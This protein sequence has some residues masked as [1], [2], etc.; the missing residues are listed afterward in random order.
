M[1]LVAPAICAA[2]ADER[3]DPA[4]EARARRALLGFDEHRPAVSCHPAALRSP[5]G[6]AARSRDVEHEEAARAERA[7]DAAEERKQG[8][9]TPGAAVEEVVEALPER[10]H[11]VARRQL[12]PVQRRDV[13]ARARDAPARS[14][15]HGVREVDPDRL[16]AR[17]AQHARPVPR[18][19]AE[20]DDEPARDPRSPEER[21]ERGRRADREPGEPDLVDVREVG[22]IR[23]R[24]PFRPLSTARRR[25]PSRS[26]APRL[27]HPQGHARQRLHGHR[28][29]AGRRDR[30]DGPIFDRATRA[31][32]LQP[33]A[34]CP[35]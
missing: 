9:R 13:E 12:R 32:P 30:A 5:A 15:H 7:V 11:G 31:W 3:R 20:V 34:A 25:E 18:P 29:A 26:R 19:A 2:G 22:S 27:L 8:R 21:E 4:R 24:H 28:G 23:A 17:V 10:G 16:V 6:L 14:S 35:R 33:R 1:G